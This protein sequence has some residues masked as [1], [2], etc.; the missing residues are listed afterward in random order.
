MKGRVHIDRAVESRNFHTWKRF[1]E[2][3]RI[4]PAV[5]ASRVGDVVEFARPVIEKDGGVRQSFLQELQERG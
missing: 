1:P 4:A 2:V 3:I 5:L